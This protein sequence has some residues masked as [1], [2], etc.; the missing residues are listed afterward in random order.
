MFTS[1]L[2]NVN[3]AS[4]ITTQGRVY[5]ASMILFF[6]MFL[7]DNVKF[8]SLDEVVQFI[9]N[10][11]NEGLSRQYR[12]VDW[13]N[14][15][16]SPEECFAKVVRDTG[17]RWV[18]S[19]DEMDIIWK[20][21]N[22]LSQEDRNRVYY[23]NN[24]FEFC[25]NDKVFM[26]LDKI[27]H[28]LDEPIMTSG[29]IPENVMDDLLLFRSILKEYVYYRYLFI[30]RIE[31]CDNMI[32]SVT[33]V[34]DTDSA[35][36]SLDGWYR[37]V[38]NKISGESF[39]IAN[40][41]E[42]QELKEPD[43]EEK[44]VAEKMYSY[45]FNKD[46]IIEI[47]KESNPMVMPGDENVKYSIIN[48]MAFCIDDFVNDYM[49]KVCENT[50]S[51]LPKY[52]KNC[53]IWSKN[54]YYFSRLLM[55]TNKK[56]YAS[57]MMIQE[58]NMVPEDEQLD[59]K[60]IQILT[61]SVTPLSTRKALKKILLEDILKTPVVDQVKFIKDIAVLEKQ[62]INSVR[63]G[64]KE[65]YK[66]ATVKAIGAYSDPMKIQGV[67]ASIAWNMIK[68]ND[69]PGLNT[70]ERNP[71]DIAKVIINRAT[72][73]KIKDT[74]PE[75]YNNILKALDDDTFKT[76]AAHPDPKT[77]EKKLLKNEI[78][79]VALPLDTELPEWLEPFIDY[80]SIITD[81]LNGFPYES[82]GIQ[83]MNRSNVGYT[84]I[85]SL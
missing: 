81:N 70:D 77:G 64:S 2:Y 18:P 44:V 35:I 11:K 36:I 32:K 74:Y 63:D 19:E 31:R 65:Y 10:V 6:E 53:A 47:E 68:T 52:H 15:Y 34:S 12:D 75:V 50:N 25:S 16:V 54:E 24:L 48:I 37:F 30:D 42:R 20:I 45:D 7:N 33:M 5:T 84:N 79:S 59:V 46:D 78:T 23:K 56:N 9:N 8:G 27:L 1:L 3:V 82:I 49:R 26:L 55:T 21:I 22:N 67:K 60:G 72:A 43:E 58:G 73:E 38:A 61:K 4:T 40:D 13:L 28:E 69:Y 62:I 80:N 41:T 85:V 29:N 66:P 17:Y 57:I 76:Y 14:H 71:V 39:K 51:L 83:R